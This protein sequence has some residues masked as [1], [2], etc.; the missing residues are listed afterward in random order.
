M[1]IKLSALEARLEKL[2]SSS[3]F[4]DVGANGLQ[5]EASEDIRSIICGVTA[6]QS[7]IDAAVE[8]G[9]DAIVVH[10]GLV[11]G[12]GI[13]YLKGWLGRRV[14]TLMR[15]NISLL[16][17]HLPLDAHP[18]VGNNAGLADH[19][20][21]IQR[22]PFS[23]FRGQK[24]GVSGLLEQET[25]YDDF[26]NLVQKIN[27]N[28]LVMGPQDKTIRTIGICSGGA[29]DGLHEAIDAGLDAYIT[30]ESTEWCQALAEETE[31]IFVAAGHHA[32]ERFGPRLLAKHLE[33]TFKQEK[34]DITVEF[35][36]VPNP[37]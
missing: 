26:V 13:R 33:R 19:F 20:G 9:A 31:T 28:A 17:Y 3:T 35:I 25:R 2:L 7:L 21:L 15:H 30:G 22:E 23:E 37:A 32:T 27:P 1:T 12:G 11:W 18:T 4:K 16:A 24:V 36:D 5:V 8:R 6:N 29:T 10:H 34:K 14:R